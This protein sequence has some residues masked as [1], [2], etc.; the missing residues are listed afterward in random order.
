MTKILTL[1]E[2][3]EKQQKAHKHLQSLNHTNISFE[4]L[5]N[6][7]EYAFDQIDEALNSAI[8]LLISHEIYKNGF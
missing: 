8:E 1:E 3:Q 2:I 7:Y 4:K 6:I 5:A